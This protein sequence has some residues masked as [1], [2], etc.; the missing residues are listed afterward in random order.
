MKSIAILISL[1]PLNTFGQSVLTDTSF[2]SLALQSVESLTTA[3]LNIF[4]EAN[5]PVYLLNKGKYLLKEVAYF[6]DDDVR[7]VEAQIEDP[8]ISNWDNPIF[9]RQNINI[10][11]EKTNNECLYLSFP[12]VSQDE[13]IVVI[14]FEVLRKKK[15]K[16]SGSGTMTVWT[17]TL[18]NEWRQARQQVVWIID[19]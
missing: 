13:T 9:K 14:Y 4:Y 3:N 17:K 2:Y 10:I 6:S 15:R 7:S 18:L 16:K 8:I 12:L 5:E 11:H 19:P 1:I